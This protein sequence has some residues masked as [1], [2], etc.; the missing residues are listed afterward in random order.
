MARDHVEQMDCDIQECRV[1]TRGPARRLTRQARAAGWVRKLEKTWRDDE[2]AGEIWS[3]LCPAHAASAYLRWADDYVG[4]Y[5]ADPWKTAFRDAAARVSADVAAAP[6][7]R[8]ARWTRWKERIEPD[9]V[10][11]MTVLAATALLLAGWLLLPGVGE[12]GLEAAEAARQRRWDSPELITLPGPA[13]GQIGK[14]ERVM[15]ERVQAGGEHDQ[16]HWGD[17]LA[18]ILDDRHRWTAPDE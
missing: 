5:G 15:L 8:E 10:E 11:P 9:D 12:I 1:E 14:A 18:R 3:D 7:E 4:K 17:C 13:L 2:D 16:R 6:A